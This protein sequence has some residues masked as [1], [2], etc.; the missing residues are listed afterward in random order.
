[1]KIQAS[2][3]LDRF[4]RQVARPVP[5]AWFADLVEGMARTWGRHATTRWEE[6]VQCFVTYFSRR[7]TDPVLQ[8]VQEG[9]A[10]DS[11]EPFYWHEFR[12]EARPHPFDPARRVGAFVAVD[13]E[14]LGESGVRAWL[15][16]ANLWS[17]R[18]EHRDLEAAA[19]GV[20]ARNEKRDRD[21]DALIEGASRERANRIY[22]TV[23]GNIQVPVVADLN[24]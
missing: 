22:R 21:N 24:P 11:G 2:P 19:D 17:G 1:M 10:E 12:R 5:P 23:T 18:G 8:R 3:I 7:S 14:Q 16:R 13:V 20:I 4:G 9:R 6:A 15:D